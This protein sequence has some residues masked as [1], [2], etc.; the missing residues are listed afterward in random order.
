[1]S[2]PVISLGIMTG[3]A[4]VLGIIYG[5]HQA[6]LLMEVNRTPVIGTRG[7]NFM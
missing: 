4:L 2:F 6:L 7:K 3:L 5:I 1:M